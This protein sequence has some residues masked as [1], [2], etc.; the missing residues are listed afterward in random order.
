MSDAAAFV[1]N[2]P[3]AVLVTRRRDGGLQASPIRVQRD[4]EGRIV[5]STRTSTAKAR[6]AARDPEVALCVLDSGWSGPWM[7][8]E[9]TAELVHL[10]DALP[11]LAAFY[12]Q[13]DGEIGDDE[14]FAA[15]MAGEGRVLLIVHPTRNTTPRGA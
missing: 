15:K 1:A 12:R 13:R 14:S 2:H 8:I 4:A 3:R 6:N 5:A 11:M 10:P 9:G 7:T